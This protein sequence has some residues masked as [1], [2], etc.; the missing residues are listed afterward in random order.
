MDNKPLDVPGEV[1]KVARIALDAI[2]CEAGFASDRF[3]SEFVRAAGDD[4]ARPERIEDVEHF[5]ELAADQL[6]VDRELRD[7]LV[8]LI[9]AGIRAYMEPA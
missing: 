9:R 4:M 1:A 8:Y 6:L 2:A 3:A 5:A 7:T